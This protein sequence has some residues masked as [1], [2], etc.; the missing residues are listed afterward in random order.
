[1]AES[2]APFSSF[3]NFPPPFFLFFFFFNAGALGPSV[4]AC[5]CVY[6]SALFDGPLDPL[7]HCVEGD[8]SP[9]PSFFFPLFFF[10]PSVSAWQQINS[11]N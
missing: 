3:C 2:S 9:P 1:M 5:M 7:A 4:I 10:C 8:N 11:S 6:T